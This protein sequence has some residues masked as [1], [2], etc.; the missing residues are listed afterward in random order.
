M[1]LV[2]KAYKRGCCVTLQYFYFALTDWRTSRSLWWGTSRTCATLGRYVRRRADPWLWKTTA[3][4]RR[5]L[6]PRTTWRYPT[7]S[8]S[9]SAMWWGTWS[10]AQ[11]ADDTVA[12]SPWPS[13]SITYLAKGGSLSE[14]GN[15]SLL[16]SRMY[17]NI[18]YDRLSN[19]VLVN[20]FIDIYIWAIQNT[21]FTEF[22]W[23]LAF[24]RWLWWLYI[25]NNN[26][27]Q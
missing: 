5:C 13:S 19:F 27:Y 1:F 3:T 23:H 2:Q 6:Q 26:M 21:S 12:P 17:L 8:Q 20:T 14:G 22:E 25:Y 15:W 18:I 10:T 16:Q 7:S 24:C 9:S 11:T 4:S